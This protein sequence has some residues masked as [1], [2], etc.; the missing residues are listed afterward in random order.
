MT[1]PSVT[2][3]ADE[4]D[5]VLA[6]VEAV[7]AAAATGSA[8]AD[9]LDTL[10]VEIQD[11]A[12]SESRAEELDRILGLALHTGR[13]RAIHG[14]GG[15]QAALKAFRK[16]PSGVEAARAAAEVSEA[17]GALAGR[18]LDAVQVTVTGPGSFSLSFTADGAEVSVRL[19]R[20]GARV[21]SL[22]L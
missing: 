18:T 7:R 10:A 2:L 6:E 9:L 14:P 20:S 11:G 13:V 21:A 16:L 22:A 17:L 12:V 4:R 3:R 5:V 15:E 19:D 1:E 8:Y